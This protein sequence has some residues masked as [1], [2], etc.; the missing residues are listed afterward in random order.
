M[1]L[2]TDWGRIEDLLL[3]NTFTETLV[4]VRAKLVRDYMVSHSIREHQLSLIKDTLT[5]IMSEQ[6]HLL[7]SKLSC[8]Y[9]WK[10]W[11]LWAIVAE[12]PGI[13]QEK[14]GY[15]WYFHISTK[16]LIPSGRNVGDTI[17]N[18]K[19]KNFTPKG[20]VKKIMKWVK[21]RVL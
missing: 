9:N 7:W 5:I 10:K 3:F 20:I 19:I 18:R 4:I 8:W 13:N 6:K 16:T 12:Q 21:I 1:A 15:T 14:C 11:F 17:F 2:Q